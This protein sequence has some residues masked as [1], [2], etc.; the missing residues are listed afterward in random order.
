[1]NQETEIS[2]ELA[3]FIG[4]LSGQILTHLNVNGAMPQQQL[5]QWICQVGWS[6][7]AVKKA[8]DVLARG[9]LVQIDNRSEDAMIKP[10]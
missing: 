8:I 3:A 6:S 7:I 10:A 1:M 2:P 4:L 5:I 9:G